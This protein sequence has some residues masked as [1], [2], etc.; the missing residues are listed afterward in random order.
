MG[1]G[2]ESPDDVL[3][4]SIE[5]DFGE[6]TEINAVLIQEYIPLGQRVRSFSIEALVNDSFDQVATGVTVGNRRIVRFETITTEKLKI[7]LDAK[8]CP[9][10]SNIEVYRVPDIK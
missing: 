3:A 4:A 5:L 2:D 7:N 8:A 9:L 6:P 10:I 1:H